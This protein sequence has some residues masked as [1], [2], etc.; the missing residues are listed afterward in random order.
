[1]EQKRRR[2]GSK[3]TRDERERHG[4]LSKTRSEV[5]LGFGTEEKEEER[6]RKKSETEAG[7]RC[8]RAMDTHARVLWHPPPPPLAVCPR[9][10]AQPFTLEPV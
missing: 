5:G 4:C 8:I 3:S 7:N 10:P 6:K 1:M 9:H 2:L